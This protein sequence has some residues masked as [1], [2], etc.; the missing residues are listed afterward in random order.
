M[1]PLPE[2][3]DSS[4]VLRT[5]FSD[6]TTWSDVRSAIVTPVGDLD[7]LPLV[8]FVDDRQYDGLSIEGLL[9][10]VPDG[11]AHTLVFLVDHETL[12]HPDHPVL[13]VD[14]FEQSGRSFRVIPSWM[15]AVENN[16]SIA[17]MDWEDF[18]DY[19]DE[20]GVFRGFPA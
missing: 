9:K 11:S 15:W 6:D 16:L 12:T 3:D 8:E 2:T 5:A 18:A 13:V 17:N 1:K 14:L 19:T 7:L 4:L 10:L 20:D